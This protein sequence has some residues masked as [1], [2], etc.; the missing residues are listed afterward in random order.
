MARSGGGVDDRL[1]ALEVVESLG[2]AAVAAKLRQQLRA[3]GV[4]VPRGKAVTTRMNRAGL[5]AR[6][7]EVLQL[8]G[9]GLTNPAIADR[10]F[11]SPR[12]VENHVERLTQLLGAM[13]PFI[14]TIGL[15]A[16][17]NPPNVNVVENDVVVVNEPLMR[18]APRSSP[19]LSITQIATMPSAAASAPVR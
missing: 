8:L 3:D 11:V 17:V 10:L 19:L 16:K 5:T 15:T 7:N 18:I 12:T 1:A 14:P 9:E 6:Q 2:A 13:I 4:K